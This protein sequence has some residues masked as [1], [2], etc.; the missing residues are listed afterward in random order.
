VLRPDLTPQEWLAVLRRV[1][2]G[3]LPPPWLSDVPMSTLR[4][5]WRPAAG[6]IWQQLLRFWGEVVPRLEEDPA[7]NEEIFS[8][9]S[10]TCSAID[11]AVL[12]LG[13]HQDREMDSRSV[14]KALSPIRLGIVR[15]L[16]EIRSRSLAS[17]PVES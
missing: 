10:V 15:V 2:P 12:M 3:T 16:E 8:Q 13:I 17:I 1:L 9:L 6:D 4:L 14:I 7:G 5:C 11:R